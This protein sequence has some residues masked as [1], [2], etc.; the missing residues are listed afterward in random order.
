MGLLRLMVAPSVGKIDSRS[1][2][3]ISNH[4]TRSPQTANPRLEQSCR[5]GNRP[6]QQ[7]QLSDTAGRADEQA[8][9]PAT[10]RL[11]AFRSISVPDDD[12]YS[13]DLGREEQS[14]EADD[15]AGRRPQRTSGRPSRDAG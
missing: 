12:P 6:G 10:R 14:R 5:R 4:A 2:A 3:R 1:E 8:V 15:G 13:R 7:G 9:S 11:V